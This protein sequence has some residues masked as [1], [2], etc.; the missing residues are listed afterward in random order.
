MKLFTL[1]ALLFSTS[2]F[3]CWNMKASLSVNE[4]TVVINQK[5]EHDKI[6]SFPKGNLIYNVTVKKNNLITID[7][8]EKKGLT[9]KPITSSQIIVKNGQEAIMTKQ[10]E[11]LNQLSTF[12]V[13]I[14]EI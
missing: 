11:N 14:T 13:K 6:Y 10:D 3:A 1:I 4:S 8:V 2:S 9:L 5:I 12:K 7:V